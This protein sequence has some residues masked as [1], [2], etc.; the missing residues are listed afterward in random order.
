MAELGIG[1]AA[2]CFSPTYAVA[3]AKF[4]MAA[5][6]ASARVDVFVNDVATAPDGSSLS[7]D[8]AVLGPDNAKAGFLV[9]SGTHGPEGFVGS[10]AQLALLDELAVRAGTQDIRLVL[11]HAVNPWG[12]SHVIRTTENH[13]DLNRNFIDWAK[14]PVPNAR[15]EELHPLLCPSDFSKAGQLQADEAR[16]AWIEK[17]GQDAYFDTMAKGQYTRHDGVHYGGTAPEWSNRTLQ[18]IVERHLARVE[19]LA[20]IDWHTGLGEH[21]QPFFLCFNEPGSDGWERACDWW[22]R[23]RVET[24]GGFD[25]ASRPGYQGL[26]FHGVQR[27]AHQASVTGAVIEFGT[28]TPDAMREAMAIEFRLK[29]GGD[30]AAAERRL[31][32]ADFRDAFSPSSLDWQAS[33]LSHAVDIQHRT[34]KGL[35]AW[36]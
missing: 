9:V 30:I 15:Y 4:L 19:R 21:G 18:T 2:S 8:V 28:R 20:V 3:R 25:G 7:T 5:A 27:Y 1:L 17:N 23:D 33:T 32:H 24:R 34:I 13:V 22:G 31:L 12:F 16:K 29:F 35:K 11:V 14:G 26:L 10:A 36:V 6:R